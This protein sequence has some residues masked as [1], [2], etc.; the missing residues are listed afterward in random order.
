MSH[1]YTPPSQPPTYSW[2]ILSVLSILMGFAAIST[3]FYLPAIPAMATSLSAS[4]KDMA[5]TISGYLVGFSLGQLFWGPIGD[6]YGRRL[7]IAGGLVLFTLGSIGCAL[8]HS[9]D[10]IIIWR[11]LQAMGACASVVLA[12]AMVRDLYEGHHATRMMSTLMTITAATPLLAP[13]IGGQIFEFGGW[14]SIF[15]VLSMVGCL[16]LVL[17]FTLPETLPIERRRHE[18]FSTIFSHYNTLILQP[19]ILAYAGAGGCLYAGMFAYISGSP[20]AYITYYHVPPTSYGFLFGMNIIGI[21]VANMLNARFAQRLGSDCLLALGCT[22]S[23]L[24]GL[25]LIIT[26]WTQWGGLWGLAVPLFFYVSTA[27]FIIANSLSGA[28]QNYPRHAGAVSA[29]VGAIHYG[30]GILGSALVGLFSNGTPRP[31]S[32]IIISAAV[33]SLLFLRLLKHSK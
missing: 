25:C 15:W 1:G 7:P 30:S 29:L 18:P 16:T 26:A 23:T 17:L 3:D 32:I 6:H 22:L 27:G 11:I 21:M 31:M 20:A 2:R 28:L 19:R 33:L 13:S 4:A 10:M 8:S 24:S 5:L 14:R 12:R 9:V